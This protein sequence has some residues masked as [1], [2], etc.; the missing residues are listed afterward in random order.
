MTGRPTYLTADCEAVKPSM[1][2]VDGWGNTLLKKNE[3]PVRIPRLS[4]RMPSIALSILDDDDNNN[5]ND[6]SGG[7]NAD[8]KTKMSGGIPT[9][10]GINGLQMVPQ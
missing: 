2:Q 7:G 9:G 6:D 5:N 4:W 8:R 1:S 10:G 3:E